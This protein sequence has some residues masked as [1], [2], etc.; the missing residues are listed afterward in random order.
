MVNNLPRI[1][2]LGYALPSGIRNNDDP[3]FDW[4]K[5]NNPA[6][7]S[8]FK[9]YATRHVLA[10]DENLMTIMVPA[11]KMAMQDAGIQ[12]QDVDLLIGTASVSHFINPNALSRVHKEL[13][14]PESTWVIPLDCEFSNFNAALFFANGL[15][16]AGS[17][18]NI[19]I[20]VGGNWTRNVD[21]HT[22]QAVSAADGAGAAVMAMSSDAT[23]WTFVDQQTITA[24]KYYGSM[25][26]LGE[27]VSLN[28]PVNGHSELYTKH[29]FHITDEGITGFKEFGV[30]TTP[31]A[32]TGLLKKH[33]LTGSDISL[34]SH[35]ASSVLMDHWATVIQP[36]QYINTIK[37]FANM[38]PSNIPV[39]LAWSKEFDP[40][41]KD[42]L[43]LLSIG[44]DMHANA[45]LYKRG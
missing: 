18:R 1:T 16:L 44:P 31:L 28:P 39:N 45:S 13:E 15:L 23:K 5:K 32:V 37:D 20:C 43:V 14:L 41:V 34:I 12:P 26:S 35:Q 21:Y 9:G 29:T 36:A 6:G 4:L 24:S 38:A 17:A 30:N 19:L 8:L 2:G 11:A 25:Y 42:Y 33:Q 3:I 7:E 22:P 10:D 27:K 40:P